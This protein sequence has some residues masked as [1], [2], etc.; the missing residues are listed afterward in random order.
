MIQMDDRESALVLDILRNV[1]SDL[2]MTIVDTENYEWRQGMKR[3]E[4]EIKQLIGRLEAS[5][6]QTVS[7]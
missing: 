4:D 7:R 2:R 6:G 1:L 5:T 3:Q